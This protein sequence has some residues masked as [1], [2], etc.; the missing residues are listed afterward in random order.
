MMPRE[1]VVIPARRR[2]SLSFKTRPRNATLSTAH[3]FALE[4]EVWNGSLCVNEDYNND[5]DVVEETSYFPEPVAKRRAA[6]SFSNLRHPMDG[7]RAL[8]RRLSVTI[9][10]KSSRHASHHH[11]HEDVGAAVHEPLDASG[12]GEAAAGQ[13]WCKGYNPNRRPSLTY[14]TALQT[15]YAP[16]ASVPAPI[17]GRGLEPPIL[18]DNIYAGAAARAAAAAQNELA[19]AERDHIKSF[20]MRVTR[21]SESGIDIDLRDRSELSEVDLAIVRIDPVTYL[22]PEIMSLA[23]SYLD[24]ESLMQAELVS[25]AW[26]E[27]AS[28]QHIWRQVF[29]RAY[30]HRLPS[31]VAPKKRQSAGL[32]KSIP[33]QDWKK[34][35]LVRRALD[36]RWKE[37]KAAAIYLHGHTDSVYCVQFD[38]DKII[39][40][41][42][43]RTIRVWD[44]HY[45]WP[46]RKII[47]PP[48]GE[49]SSIG[50]VNNPT[51]QSSGKPPFLT[52]C[53]P[54]TLSA[55][56]VTPID[57]SSDYHSASILCLQFDEEIMVTGSSDFTCIVWDIKNDYRPIRRLEGH[58]AGVLDVCFDDRYIVSCSKDTTI[59]VWDRQTGALVKKLLGHRGPVNAVQL[60]GDLVVSASGDGVAKLWNITSGLCVK[61]FASKD[62]GLACVEFSDDARTILTGGNDQSIYQFDAN[63]AEMVREL[64]GHAGL[65]RSLHLDSMNKR[66]VSGSYDM[67]VKVFDAQTGELSIDLPGWT[68]SWMLSVKS[69]YRRIVATSQDSRAVIMDFG[70]G[71][72]GIEL[73]EE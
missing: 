17:P 36:H 10:H 15:F 21:D 23:L 16:F 70:Y 65:V 67:S 71:L 20:D 47:G 22:P 44:A 50:Q 43:D 26:S 2:P 42:R 7:L 55:G 60:R 45:P 4:H 30:G 35:F 11:A 28:S 12:P 57:Q 8:G 72:D 5:E 41:S 69:D 3:P 33:N 32:G 39:T 49:V 68:T 34:M 46:C 56:I 64:K 27:Q 38:E 73:L 19:R 9:R 18:P 48:P 51:Q 62:R 54:P 24:P 6:K 31:G 37:G 58:R 14:E 13:P 59:C 52:I 63:T 66:I 1:P 29:R 53:P 61:E 25:R 40:G